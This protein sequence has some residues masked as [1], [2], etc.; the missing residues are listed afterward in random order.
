M[1]IRQW[2]LI[3]L[4]G[5]TSIL[6]ACSGGTTANVQNPPPPVTPQ[7]SITFQP[8]PPSSIVIGASAPVSAVVNNDPN[9]SG[10]DWLLNCQNA[11]TCGSLSSFHTASGQAT[12]YTPPAT[13]SSNTL[14]VSIVAYAT[15][16][17]SENV[18]T[19]LTVTAFGSFLKAGTYIVETTGIT[20]SL[21]PC[22]RVAA[23]VLDGNG[24]VTG[25]EQ[26]VEF[27]NPNTSVFS[28][29]SDAVTG[30]GYFIGPD[31]RGTLTI[32]TA[33]VNV[34]QQGIESF[35]LVA[36]SNSQALL[37]KTDIVSPNLA[38]SNE[39]SV[40][41]MDLQVLGGP[42]TGG[43]ALLV[44][45]ANVNSSA[46][47]YGSAVAFGGV[48]NIDGPQSISGTGSKFD[49]VVNGFTTVVASSSVSGSL[50]APDSFGTIKITLNTDF[51]S[52]QLFTGYVIDATHIKLIETDS[53][54]GTAGV[55]IGQGSLTGTFSSFSGT[56][57]LGIFGEDLSGS[58]ATLAAAAS[59]TAGAGALSNGTIDELQS[60]QLVQISDGFSATYTVDPS[61]RVDTSSSFTFTSNGPGP[62][63]VFYLTGGG[64]PVLVLDADTEP[65][66]SGGGVG[67]GLAY[68]STAGANFSGDYGLS[69]TQNFTGTEGDATGAICVN[70]SSVTCPPPGGPNTP[71]GS[72]NT[73]AGIVDQ[74][75]GFSPLG[76]NPLTGEFQTSAASGRLTGTLSDTPNFPS[77]PL[78]VA[79]YLI[80]SGHGFFVETDGGSGQTNPGVLTFGYFASRVPVCQGCP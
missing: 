39:S 50:V 73:L 72:P 28:S 67:T 5:I 65:T 59:F 27:T 30:G 4:S 55:A 19:S 11:P 78:S 79:F 49:E 76:P 16:N 18:N 46:I 41:T 45:G 15:A 48:L 77:N 25:G 37:T 43:Y 2:G 20:V 57:T 42:P 63:L 80:D 33:D 68:P 60:S 62:D 34:G 71:P 6:A 13:M 23:I 9:N 61:G 22:L 10:V 24:N 14:D 31:G 3:F 75:L 44:R 53:N 54:F 36:L 58:P 26:T 74:T 69:F 21:F 29:V 1:A 70:A 56:Y 7:V 17:H 47:A 32:N 51:G 12:T 66:L 35:S 38:F 52:P 64:N 8:S 40:G